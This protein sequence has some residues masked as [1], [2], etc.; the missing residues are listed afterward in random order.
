MKH[1]L[2]LTDEDCETLRKALRYLD[3]NPK[4]A[5]KLKITPKQ[6][7]FLHRRFNIEGPRRR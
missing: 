7:R 6:I 4:T 1:R 2:T 3:E 5:E